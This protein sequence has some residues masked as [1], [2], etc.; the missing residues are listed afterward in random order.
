MKK[1]LWA[2][3]L[4]AVLVFVVPMEHKYDKPFRIFS[5]TLIPQGLVISKHYDKKI[6]FYISDLIAMGLFFAGLF[7][8]RIPLRRFLGHPLWIVFLCALVSIIASPFAHYPIAY[9]RLLQLFTAVA[10]FS[11]LAHAFTEAERPKIT[12]LIFLVLVTAALFQTAVAI[13]QYFH[14]APLGLRLLGEVKE[15]SGLFGIPNGSRWTFDRLFHRVTDA[16]CVIRASGTLPHPNVLGGFFV[17]SILTTYA[18]VMQGRKKEKLFFG[19]TLPFQIFAMSLSFSRAALFAWTLGTVIW[20]ALMLFKRRSVQ[21]LAF[22][23]ALSVVIT[24]ALLYE[25]YFYRGGVINYNQLAKD[26]DTVR[27]YHQKTAVQIIK[28]NPLFGLGFSQFTERASSYFPPDV[29]PYV[30]LTGPH[31]IFLFLAAETGI[32]SLAAFLLFVFTL[33]WRAARAPITLETATLSSLFVAFLFISCC[34]FYPLLFQQGKLLFFSIAGLLAAHVCAQKKQE[35]PS[36]KEVWKMFDLISPTYDRINRILSLGMD[37]RWRKRVAQFLPE[38]SDL[39]LIDL[40]TGT[41][42]QVAALLNSPVSI[43]SITGIDLSNEMLAIARKKIQQKTEFFHAD[44]ENIPFSDASFDAATF[45]FGIR[46]VNNPLRSLQEI[47]RILKSRGRCLVLEFSLPPQPIRPFYLLYLRHILP[48]VGGL[49]SKKPAAYRYLNQTIEQFPS[50]K[51]FCS[52]MNQAGFTD[53]QAIPMALGGV[54]LYV[55]EKA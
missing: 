26:S 30:R 34:D 52:L 9:A 4:L 39:K 20:F 3:L 53:L 23:I 42:D 51:D 24:S 6:Y 25:Q 27:I 49:L 14:Q 38:R 44:A 15:S 17:A 29:D 55:G 46:N 43:Q 10:L 11:F 41:G 33:L 21:F 12:R 18:L 28:E 32:I 31:N 19:L 8:F 37:Q 35:S 36:R 5:K 48:R 16:T 47:H 2:A 45:S 50:G 54:T 13:V 1:F 22:M 40:A 7:W